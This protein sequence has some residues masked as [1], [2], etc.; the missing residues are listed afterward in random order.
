[1]NP[2]IIKGIMVLLSIALQL[3]AG[4]PTDANAIMTAIAMLGLGSAVVRRPGDLEPL[5]GG[6]PT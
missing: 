3:Y 5:K 2:R 6:S 1:M 4:V